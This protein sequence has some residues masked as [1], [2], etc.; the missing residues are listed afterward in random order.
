M[1]LFNDVVRYFRLTI[2]IATGQPK[3][4][5]ILFIALM[6]VVLAPLLSM[7]IF[8]GKP[9]TSSARAKNFVAAALFLRL[10]S[11]KFRVL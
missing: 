2:S 8:R 9:L 3:P 6:P 5:S 7:T 1:V 4:F 11:R 10:D